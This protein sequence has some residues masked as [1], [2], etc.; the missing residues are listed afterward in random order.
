MMEIEIK[1]RMA[2]A[3]AAR[4][5]LLKLGARLDK[6]RALEANTLYDFRSNSLT[7]QHRALRLRTYGRKCFLTFKGSP[8]KSRRFK[9]REE[10]EVEVR[11]ERQARKILQALGFV[12]VFRY[13]KHRTV[14]RRDR[15]KVCLDETRLGVFLELEGDR[16]RIIRLVKLLGVAQAELIKLDYIQMYQQAGLGPD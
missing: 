5:Q 6:D 11:N 4:D 3:A 9:V 2:S 13:E 16:S 15:L 8:Q 1:V 7:E 14:F 10:F 12:P